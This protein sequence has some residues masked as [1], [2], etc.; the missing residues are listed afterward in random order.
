MFEKTLKFDKKTKH[1][2]TNTRF[3]KKIENTEK[4][5]KRR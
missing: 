1:Y 2:V 3:F 4:T 5:K